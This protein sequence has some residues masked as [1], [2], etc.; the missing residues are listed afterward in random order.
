MYRASLTAAIL[1]LGT[2]LTFGPAHAAPP[3]EAGV[4]LAQWRAP[5]PWADGETCWRLRR[6]L[7]RL[8]AIRASAP[9]WERPGI[10]PGIRQTRIELR[11]NCPGF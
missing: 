9:P 7:H 5:P 1:G 11:H 3:R 8:Y 2:L 4:I 6:Q 10:Q